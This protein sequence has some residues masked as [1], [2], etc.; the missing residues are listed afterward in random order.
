M[1]HYH[2]TPYDITAPGFFFSTYEEYKDR[3]SK[4]RNEGG[5]PVEECEIQFID[6]DNYQLFNELG[7]NQANLKQWFDEYEQLNEEDAT[8]A[9]F[10]AELGYDMSNILENIDDVYLFEGTAKEYAEQYLEDTGLL[11]EIPESLRF[12]FDTESFARDL[13]YSGDITEIN[14]NGRNYIAQDF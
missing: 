13:L 3:A 1:S 8:K 6:G 9:I 10:L 5:E 4:H 14:I 2:A 7:I 12:Y 11:E